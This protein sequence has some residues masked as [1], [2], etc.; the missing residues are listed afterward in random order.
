MSEIIASILGVITGLIGS[1]IGMKIQ[2]N[3][4]KSEKQNDYRDDIISMID[5]VVFKISKIRN[6]ELSFD[7]AIINKDVTTEIYQEI[8]SDFNSF[9]RQLQE[10]IVMMS[11]HASQPNKNIQELLEYYQPV[12]NQFNNFKTSYRI[13]NQKYDKIEYEERSRIAY[14]KLKFERRV[15]EFV[16]NMRDFSIKFYKHNMYDPKLKRVPTKEE[17]REIVDSYQSKSHKNKYSSKE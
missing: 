13:Y 12:E 9:D 7:N 17:A 15:G 2:Y 11:H 3:K 14:S 8:V 1:L 16:E 5:I 10:L 6:N 4:N